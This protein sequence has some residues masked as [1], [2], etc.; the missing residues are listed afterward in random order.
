[1]PTWHK[2]TDGLAFDGPTGIVGSSQIR[3]GGRTRPNWATQPLRLTHLIYPLI[4]PIFLRVGLTSLLVF[5]GN[6]A[7]RDASDQ[8]TPIDTC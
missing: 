3:G 2:E 4:S 5:S 7:S 8:H 6:V 1:M